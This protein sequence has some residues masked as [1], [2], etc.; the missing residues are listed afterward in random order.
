MEKD[1]IDLRSAKVLLVDDTEAN[2]DVLCE[3]LEAE[4]YRISMAPNGEIA[5]RIAGRIMP[6]L[7]LLDVMMPGIDGFEI[8]R[9]LKG[10]EKTREIPIIFITAEDL[11]E[12]VVTGF[13]VG[14]VDYITK[15]FRD[16]EVLVRV[17]NA[18]L[19]KYLFDQNRA[20]QEKMEK[21]LQTAHELQMGLMPGE[22]P[23]LE[24]FDIAGRCLPAEQV[25]G[26]FFQYFELAQGGLAI[27]LADV[28]G[29][30][31][32]AAIPVVLFSGMLE[33]QMESGGALE[34]LFG[35][36][37]HSVHRILDSR[38]FVCFEMAQI[39]PVKR[40]LR[41]GNGGCPHPFHYRAATGEVV[42][43][44]QEETYPLGIRSDTS[45]LSLEVQLERDDRVVFFSD[46]I[47]E[48][49]NEQGE[50]FGFERMAQAIRR[51]CGNGAGAE[52]LLEGIIA[53]MR[54][55]VGETPQVDDQTV[56]ALVVE[57]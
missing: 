56:V 28:T 7:I 42:E 29:H 54:D 33:T 11:T 12:S 27:S 9:R 51:G 22:Q 50:M 48:A 3:L 1:D 44:K 26:D 5:L 38:T 20:Y 43:L 34:E 46:G 45:Y 41:M 10:D 57:R 4:E 21:E 47:V 13:E 17:R 2:L 18:L 37:N 40:C 55:F 19:T 52:S 32:E 39:D 30:A 6:D 25:G 8:C 23:R 49:E 53:E 31:M 35:R 14:G 15:P 24:G 36:L 16:R